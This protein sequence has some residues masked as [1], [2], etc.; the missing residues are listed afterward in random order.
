MDMSLGFL[1]SSGSSL[2][3]LSNR[4]AGAAGYGDLAATVPAGELS[5]SSDGT[6]SRISDAGYDGGARRL[7]TTG[8]T[9]DTYA[10]PRT[11]QR[12]KLEAELEEKQQQQQQL[13]IRQLATRD[14]EVR[15]H[16]QAHVSAGGQYAGAPTFQFERGPNGVSYAISGEVSISTG[17]EAT[18]QA[19]LQKAQVVRRA[20]LAPAEPSPQDRRVAALASQ[21]E[22][23]ARGAIAKE[24]KADAEV[25]EGK[26]VKETETTNDQT[27][28]GETT[29][30][31][32]GAKAAVGSQATPGT[33][34]SLARSG[35]FSGQPLTNHLFSAEQLNRAL[36]GAV[37]NAFA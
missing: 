1:Q 36:P 24:Q 32:D 3:S 14:R 10:D 35:H 27:A 2:S 4:V 23:R 19:T 18:P 26:A 5:A 17:D 25:E 11:E 30:T 20:A 12:R 13:E 9:S 8:S 6:I 31:G 16:E 28:A 7:T 22:A 34:S 15:A 37:L 21:M 33:I 29:V